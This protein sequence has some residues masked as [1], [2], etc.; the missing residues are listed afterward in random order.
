M[1]YFSAMKKNKGFTLIEVLV[2]VGIIGVLA[3]ILLIGLGT[4][5]R[6]GADTRRIAD[7]RTMQNALELYATKCGYYP[8]GAT[9]KTSTD[10]AVCVSAGAP[11]NWDELQA[12]LRNMDIGIEKIPYDPAKAGG[13]FYEYATPGSGASQ[14]VLRALLDDDGNPALAD[15]FDGTVFGLV[16]GDP[17]YCVRF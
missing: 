5:R 4:L 10:P 13:R 17:A 15:D 6:K 14:Y 9:P 1:I 3:S 12:V 2:V 16:C 11:A 8:G 7:L